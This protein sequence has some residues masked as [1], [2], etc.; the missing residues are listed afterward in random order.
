[1]SHQFQFFLPI[2]FVDFYLSKFVLD[3]PQ[4]GS[5]TFMTQSHFPLCEFLI[6]TDA[7]SCNL[8]KVLTVLLYLYINSAISTES[9]ILILHGNFC[10]MTGASDERQ[11]VRCASVISDNFVS[12]IQ[13][14]Y[15][16]HGRK[17]F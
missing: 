4:I 11:R 8:P 16:M 1:M 5:N 2:G 10:S 7:I 9:S 13:G 6:T 17:W 12:S 3:R 15:K 14:V